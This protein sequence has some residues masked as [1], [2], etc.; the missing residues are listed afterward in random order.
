MPNKYQVKIEESILPEL[1]TFDQLINAGLLDEVDEMIKVRLNGDLTWFTARSFP[2]SDLESKRSAHCASVN[3]RKGDTLVHVRTATIHN[4]TLQQASNRPSTSN[5]SQLQQEYPPI[6][7]VWNW[8]AFS[9]SWIWGI[10]NGLYWPIII[11]VLNF[12]PYVGVIIS[13]CICILLGKKGNLYAWR[14]AKQ[15]GDSVEHFTFIQSK[16]N[17]AGLI[18]VIVFIFFLFGAL[19][20]IYVL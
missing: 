7:E 11:I 4:D 20:M 16:W 8:G 18:G 17:I 19:L 1:Y 5:K 2:F 15:K 6:I 10:F 13:L 3:E 14:M 12:I 9:L